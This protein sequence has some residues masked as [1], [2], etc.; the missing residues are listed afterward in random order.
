MAGQSIGGFVKDYLKYELIFEYEI[1]KFMKKV[2]QAILG[3]YTP[4]GGVMVTEDKSYITF[5]QAMVLQKGQ[6]IDD[7]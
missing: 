1:N 7:E 4:V 5:Y 6:H 2:N 3:G